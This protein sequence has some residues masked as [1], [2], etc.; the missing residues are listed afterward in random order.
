[1]KN[2]KKKI[3][4]VV[5]EDSIKYFYKTIQIVGIYKVYEGDIILLG[6]FEK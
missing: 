4:C 1:M 3:K 2:E 5:K 6:F